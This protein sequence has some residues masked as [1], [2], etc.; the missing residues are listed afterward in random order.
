MSTKI[1]I[2]WD[3]PIYILTLKVVYDNRHKSSS[4]NWL[5]K[6]KSC[7]KHGATEYRDCYS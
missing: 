5:F 1:G 3:L 7:W 6:D 4:P 2:W